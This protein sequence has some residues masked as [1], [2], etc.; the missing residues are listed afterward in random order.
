VPIYPF[1]LAGARCVCAAAPVVDAH[2]VHLGKC[3]TLTNLTIGTHDAV[4]DVVQQMVKCSGADRKTEA[5]G[6]F[7]PEGDSPDM[8]RI[9]LVVNVPGEQQTLCDVTVVAPATTP[10]TL[11]PN[12]FD[13]ADALHS[14]E[15]RKM[16]K[17]GDA[18]FRAGKKFV[19]LAVDHCGKMGPQFQRFFNQTVNRYC[20]N[21]GYPAD[22]IHG[23]WLRR[24]LVAVQNGVA[25]SLIQRAHRVACRNISNNLAADGAASGD[26]TDHDSYTTAPADAL[27]PLWDK[28]WDYPAG[29]GVVADCL[30]ATA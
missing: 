13:I 8:R 29:A 17:Y 21:T 11:D 19:A 5:T 26:G 9:D 10:S 2:G 6:T 7:L 18:A 20:A 30:R 25:H 22:A 28:T 14:A 23:Y 4:R 1:I 12:S 3:K 15:L 27:D 24:I 16:H